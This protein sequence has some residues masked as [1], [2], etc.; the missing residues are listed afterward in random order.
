[1]ADGR[2]E[3]WS[4][5]LHQRAASQRV[6]INGTIEVTRRCS[7][8]CVHCY[9]NLAAGDRDARHRELSLDEHCR[10]LD[11]IADH[12]CLWLLYTGGEIF[13]R[14]D[15]LDIYTYAKKR[16]L[17]VSLFTNG[18]LITEE[19]ADYLAEWRPFSVEITLHGSTAETY[20]RVTRA[21]GSYEKCMRGIRLLADRG[22]PLSLK[23][24]VVTLNCHEVSAMKR[25]AVEEL[26]VGYRFDAIINP[27]VDYS[28]A[29]LKVRLEPEEIVKLDLAHGERGEAFRSFAAEFCAG[30]AHSELESDRLYQCGAGVISFRVDPYG[31]LST[32]S[33]ATVDRYDLRK[34]SFQD[35]W[36]G[37][38]SEVRGRN[39][40]RLTKCV[41][42]AIKP[43]CGMCPATAELENRDPEE[44][45][46]FLCRVAH[47]RARA[48]GIGVPPHGDCEYC[49]DS[50]SRSERVQEAA[51][52][53][54]PQ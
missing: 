49:E 23:T 7:V 14:P 32:C 17:L 18:T 39:V 5:S 10:I 48:L 38:L 41:R 12:G 30:R 21:P 6:P 31:R 16:G 20:E 8:S 45:V 35:G 19:I 37:F 42:C 28:R 4:R 11:E 34:G 25:L 51:Q 26:G 43:M 29:P 9:N 27:R 50:D 3:A 36:S 13:I 40:R 2:Y 15:F 33:L 1:M 44:A 47:L 22:V 53:G 52:S 24:T 54:E 46:D